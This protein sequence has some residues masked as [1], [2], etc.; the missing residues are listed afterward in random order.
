MP[1]IEA[2]D[3]TSLFAPDWGC[4]PPVM[5][6]HGWGLRSDQWNYQVPALVAVGLR[7]SPPSTRR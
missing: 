5:F 6:T 7:S 1:F 3:R 2:A 4:G